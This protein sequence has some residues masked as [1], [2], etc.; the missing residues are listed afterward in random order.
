MRPSP[1]AFT[2]VEVLVVISIIVILVSIL[3]P[4]LEKAMAASQRSKCAANLSGIGKALGTYLSDS[5]ARV[6]PRTVKPYGLLGQGGTETGY[7][8]TSDPNTNFGSGVRPLNKYLGISGDKAEVKIGECPSDAGGQA[9]LRNDQTNYTFDKSAPNVYQAVGTSYAEAFGAAGYL[10]RTGIQSA[11]GTSPMQAAAAKP[12]GS[13]VLLGDAPLFGE[14]KWAADRKN[15]WHSSDK[16]NRQHTI[17]FAD[18]HAELFSF[19]DPAQAG[20][21]NIE[22]TGSGSPIGNTAADFKPGRGYW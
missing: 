14:N 3:V 7:Q 9:V 12:A 10:G 16:T 20:P 5:I 4:S 17:L 21:D 6:Y 2:L 11:F 18:Y 8:E 19:K 13:K 22:N 1:K 15:R